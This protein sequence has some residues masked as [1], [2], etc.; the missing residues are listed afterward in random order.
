[1]GGIVAMSS[2]INASTASG[3]GV[4]TTADASGILQLQTAGVTALTID[5]SQN[6]SFTK[7][8]NKASLPTGSVLQVVNATLTGIVLNSTSTYA[9][10]GLTATITPTSATSKILVLSTING[11][12]KANGNVNNALALRLVRG[13]TTILNID[14]L[15]AY[16]Q[17]SL[18]NSSAASTTYVDLPATTTATTYKIQFA[19]PANA[20]FVF[21]NNYY[22]NPSE[23]NSTITLMEIAG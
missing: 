4:I 1:M 2:T 21:I 7:A 18:Y 8:I 3:G 20:A 6:V 15:L 17:T 9:D 19:N 14:G 13:S 12:G 11:A 10:T 23:T 5:A 22:S 16:T